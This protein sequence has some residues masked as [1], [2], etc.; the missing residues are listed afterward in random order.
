MCEKNILKKRV[1]DFLILS[2]KWLIHGLI[3]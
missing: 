3:D 1:D 2:A